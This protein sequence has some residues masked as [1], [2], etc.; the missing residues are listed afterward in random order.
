MS[1]PG[2]RPAVAADPVPV[3]AMPGGDFADA[4]YVAPEITIVIPTLNERDNVPVLVQRLSAALEGVA[5][6]AI[7]VDDDSKDGTIEAVRAIARRTPRIRGIRRVHRRGLAGASLEGMLASAAP[8]VALIDADLQHDET[9]LRDMLAVLRS[10][11]ADV[12]VASRYVGTVET[13]GLS[14]VRHK[15][16]RFATLLAQRLLKAPLSDPMSGFFAIRREAVEAVAPRLSDQGFKILLDILAS[17]P[18]PLRIKEI[19]YVFKPRLHGES[20]LDAAVVLEYLGLVVAKLSGDLVSIRFLMFA[21]VGTSGV[22]VNLAVLWLVLALGT[23]FAAA[24]TA[25][26]VA[27]MVAN[28]TLNNALTYRD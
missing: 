1:G 11:E 15:G 13:G 14:D 21:L 23:D 3:P 17:S 4:G 8:Y 26:M 9:R 19:P 5:W 18:E 16:S 7:F 28:Y 6:E 10:G 20:K 2:L 12:V 22:I 24:K 27:A 25:A